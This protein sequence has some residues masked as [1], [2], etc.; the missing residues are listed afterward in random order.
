MQTSSRRGTGSAKPLSDSGFSK[1]RTSSLLA[2]P[3]KHTLTAFSG[4]L[5]GNL[6]LLGFRFMLSFA[7]HGGCDLWFCFLRLDRPGWGFF[8]GY[9]CIFLVSGLQE[10]RKQDRKQQ[11]G[12]KEGGKE[13]RKEERKEGNMEGGQEGRKVG[14]TLGDTGRN[15]T[16]C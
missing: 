6:E 9:F 8:S 16:F 14:T 7:V 2:S 13:G 4:V 1:K 5:G 15:G 10:G 12:R 3:Q 11:L